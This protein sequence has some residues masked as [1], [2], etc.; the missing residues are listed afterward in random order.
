MPEDLIMTSKTLSHE[1]HMLW[2]AVPI[3]TCRCRGSKERGRSGLRGLLC[4][5]ESE[6]FEVEMREIVQQPCCY[7]AFPFA[8]FVTRKLLWVL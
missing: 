2:G 5:A 6:G 1:A 4:S 7:N 3:G 8:D